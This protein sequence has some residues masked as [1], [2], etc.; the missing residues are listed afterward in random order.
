MYGVQKVKRLTELTCSNGIRRYG[1]RLVM[2]WGGIHKNGK[3]ELVIV[4]GTFTAHHCIQVHLVLADN[5]SRHLNSLFD[6]PIYC[7]LS[8]D[9]LI[10]R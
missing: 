2:V 8:Y 4:R 1:S 5:I 6:I 7:P 9:E 10:A 3:A